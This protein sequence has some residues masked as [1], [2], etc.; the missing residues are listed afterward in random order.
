[1]HTPQSCPCCYEYSHSL[2][3]T[4]ENHPGARISPNTCRL[5]VKTP[6]HVTVISSR[7]HLETLPPRLT[8]SALVLTSPP[9]KLFLIKCVAAFAS[10]SY[11]HV[12]LAA[13]PVGAGRSCAGYGRFSR[14]G[15]GARGKR[16][17]R[18]DLGS[19]AWEGWAR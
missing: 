15:G 4:K 6:T 11:T 14:G 13:S 3:V 7:I 19:G 2:A 9:A 10:P 1:M 5:A 17:G 16:L 12:S 8:N 18:A